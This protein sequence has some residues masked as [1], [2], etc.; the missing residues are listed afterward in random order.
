ME[1]QARMEV[2]FALGNGIMEQFLSAIEKDSILVINGTMNKDA[3]LYYIIREFCHVCGK[4]C[5]LVNKQGQSK[6]LTGI[7]PWIFDFPYS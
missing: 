1:A 7:W 2:N 5:L 3:L 6:L 4:L